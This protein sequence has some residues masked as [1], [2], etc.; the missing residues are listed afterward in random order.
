MS[1]K[2]KKHTRT[3]FLWAL[4]DRVPRS[5]DHEE[6]LLI[7]L[8]VLAYPLSLGPVGSR[9]LLSTPDFNKAPQR[10]SGIYA[11]VGWVCEHSDFARKVVLACM[12]WWTTL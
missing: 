3:R 10:L 9:V 11:P 1:D 5:R 4:N 6:P 7:A 8:V 2:P 12:A